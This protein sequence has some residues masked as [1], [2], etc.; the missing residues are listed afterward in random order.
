MPIATCMGKM[1]VVFVGNFG[2][3]LGP[4]DWKRWIVEQRGGQIEKTLSA[5]TT[6]LVVE[7]GEYKK[8]P[9]I[10]KD[11]LARPSV[12]IVTSDYMEDFIRHNQAPGGKKIPL[13]YDFRQKAGNEKFNAK[14]TKAQEREINKQKKAAEKKAKAKEKEKAKKEKARQREEAKNAKKRPRTALGKELMDHTNEYMPPPK[15][16]QLTPRVRGGMTADLFQEFSKGKKK[17]RQEL[18]SDGYHIFEDSTTFRYEIAL[19]R[20]Q[21][22]F[23]VNQTLYIRIYESDEVP[24]CYAVTKVLTGAFVETEKPESVVGTGASFPT[25]FAAF[26][27]T[28]KEHTGFEWD[29]RMDFAKCR[30]KKPVSNSISTS[31]APNKSAFI[32][33]SQLH[34]MG[35]ALQTAPNKVMTQEKQDEF[36]KAKFVW[37]APHEGAP[38]GAMGPDQPL[39]PEEPIAQNPGSLTMSSIA[40]EDAVVGADAMEVG[41]GTTAS[42]NGVTKD[43]ENDVAAPEPTTSYEGAMRKESIDEDYNDEYAMAI[44]RP[45]EEIEAD[46]GGSNEEKQAPA[47]QGMVGKTATIEATTWQQGESQ[48]ADLGGD[49]WEEAEN[50]DGG[51]S[52]SNGPAAA[53]L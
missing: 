10:V 43:A 40:T 42:R 15:R 32:T 9:K 44:E 34:A 3:G 21:M 5:R 51:G 49:F 38:V 31:L 11:A 48:A 2:H 4:D 27:R 39:V 14:Q 17:G 53:N 33:P 52:H 36:L 8:K 6:H 22:E 35:G 23:N 7:P 46:K 24:R 28:F 25:A 20:I 50:A 13:Q 1:T 26:K 18:L 29:R 45:Q 47:V 41:N 12:S 30:R 16:H 19:T 37:Y